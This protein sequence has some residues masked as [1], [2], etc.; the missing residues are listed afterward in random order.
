MSQPPI[1]VWVVYDHPTDQPE[2]FIARR[3]DNGKP[4][5]VCIRH[6]V[7]SGVQVLLAMNYPNLRRYPRNP[8]DDL[9]IVEMWM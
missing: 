8:K 6:K 1:S 4:T 2:D 9:V 5:E 3:F 7:L